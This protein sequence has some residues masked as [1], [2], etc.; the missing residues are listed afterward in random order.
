MVRTHRFFG[1][2]GEKLAVVAFESRGQPNVTA[3]D[4]ISEEMR[5][6]PDADLTPAS[7][8][9]PFYLPSHS[10][11]FARCAGWHMSRAPFVRLNNAASRILASDVATTEPRNP[12]LCM[13]HDVHFST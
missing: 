7:I 11:A 4:P 3:K 5:E 9:V 12:Q 2:I 13:A 1:T 10:Y 6:I 8:P